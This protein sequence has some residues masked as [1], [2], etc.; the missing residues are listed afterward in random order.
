MN[1]CINCGSTER[2]IVKKNRLREKLNICVNCYQQSKY[3]YIRKKMN[4]D[5]IVC[6]HI[7]ECGVCRSCYNKAWRM[8][9]S[10]KCTKCG[11]KCRKS[12]NPLCT[13]CKGKQNVNVTDK[14]DMK[15]MLT[16]DKY[17]LLNLIDDLRLIDIYLNAG[18]SYKRLQ[19]YSGREDTRKFILD[20]FKVIIEDSQKSNS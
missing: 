11:E 13:I 12:L 9:S 19:L 3:P 20:S 17:K 18:L 16:K 2:R 7:K 15:R 14:D 5:G 8:N 10:D 6:S 4:V 1:E